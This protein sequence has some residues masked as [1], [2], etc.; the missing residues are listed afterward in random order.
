MAMM[1][2][3]VFER[4]QNTSVKDD[5]ERRGSNIFFVLLHDNCKGV[6]QLE[7][8]GQ[9]QIFFQLFSHDL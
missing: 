4:L 9:G 3:F 5:D 6:V 8:R 1:I 2:K 7:L